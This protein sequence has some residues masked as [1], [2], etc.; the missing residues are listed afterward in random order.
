VKRRKQRMGEL[1]H[2]ELNNWFPGTDYPNEEPFIGW[3]R[4]DKFSNDEWCKQ[5]K[6][7]VLTGYVDMSR[8]WCITATKRWVELNYPKL[9]EDDHN[10]TDFL[11]H[12]DADGEVCGMFDWHFPE[13][14]SDNYG[15]I[16]HDEV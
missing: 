5:N 7:V 2:F 15:V 13:Y 4:E 11:R 14:N 9:L 10:I 12:P 6:L 16:W 3:I 1:I 8:N